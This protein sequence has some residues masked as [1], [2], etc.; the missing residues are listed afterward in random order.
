MNPTNMLEGIFTKLKIYFIFKLIV[1][2]YQ[3]MRFAKLQVCAS[4]CWCP[5]KSDS[6]DLESIG[7]LIDRGSGN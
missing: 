2:V 4:V 3:F 6:L 1:H 7:G 5:E